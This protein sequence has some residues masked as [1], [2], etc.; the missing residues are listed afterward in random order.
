MSGRLR[1]VVL[2]PLM[3]RSEAAH[4]FSTHEIGGA[5]L[6]GALQPASKPVHALTLVALGLLLGQRADNSWQPLAI[7]AGALAGGLTAIALGIG[8][9]PAAI[10]LLASA[11][12]IGVFIAAQWT[13]PELA[14]WVL[15]AVTG[16][17]IGLDSPPT[18]VSIAA[19]N[20]T[21]VGCG[22]GSCLVL[23]AAVAARLLIRHDWQ[24][25]ALRIAGS[26]IAASAMLALALSAV[27]LQ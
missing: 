16:T 14:R 2:L 7:F 6:Q 8:P 20:A 15:A 27:R 13:L 10:A 17:A 19:A 24:R 26:W 4:A 18:A 9:T 12:L 21:L 11:A 23:S 25:I 1:H 3:V 22:L 5:L